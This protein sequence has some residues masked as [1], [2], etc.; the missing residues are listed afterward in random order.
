MNINNNASN[1][2]RERY[3]TKLIH[4]VFPDAKIKS[5]RINRRDFDQTF[6]EFTRKLKSGASV[7]FCEV[8]SVG[9]SEWLCDFYRYCWDN[10][11]SLSFIRD[12][13]F[14]TDW[15][16][17]QTSDIDLIIKELTRLHDTRMDY[18]SA[19]SEAR[20]KQLQS[21]YKRSGT[22]PGAR[23]GAER[24]GKAKDQ[25]EAIQAFFR[26]NPN[27]TYEKAMAR[28][29]LSRISIQRYKNRTP[30]KKPSKKPE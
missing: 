7:A 3:E 22:K 27:A 18:T 1:V 28:F 10:G 17:N 30:H 2:K 15:L 16:S 6:G 20:S 4:D 25:A 12:D 8:P 13:C 29:G 21:A 14:S 26:D 11:V 5:F 24:H 19:R 9:N 23:P